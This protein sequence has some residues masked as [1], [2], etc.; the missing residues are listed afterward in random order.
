MPLVD[1]FMEDERRHRQNLAD[2]VNG[3]NTTNTANFTSAA[4]G[5]V[6]AS[7]GGTTNFLRADGTWAT[8]PDTTGLS[9]A[10]Q[11]EMEAASS[12]TV[13]ATPGR[14]Q[15]HPGTAKAWVR[16]NLSAT[17]ASSYNVSSVTDVAVGRWSVNFTTAFSSAGGYCGVAMGGDQSSV[18]EA[19]AYGVN[20]ASASTAFAISARNV[21][22]SVPTDPTN[23]NEIH[24]VMFG[25][26]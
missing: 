12:T 11:A 19:L 16:F 5:T 6:A 23:L 22:D 26:Q 3:L 9:A 21:N 17:I 10:T 25:D 4:P 20:A 7:G 8:P 18:P 2:A 24:A 15:Y 1:S 13:A 14:T